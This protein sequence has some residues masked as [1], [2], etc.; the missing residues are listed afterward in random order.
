MWAAGDLPINL[1]LVRRANTV[2]GRELPAHALSV[3]S[4]GGT[5]SPRLCRVTITVY[6]V[7]A[8]TQ[9]QVQSVLQEALGSQFSVVAT[10]ALITPLVGR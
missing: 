7:S 4:V 3:S 8:A 6:G 9:Q 2:A 5:W 10:E 1:D